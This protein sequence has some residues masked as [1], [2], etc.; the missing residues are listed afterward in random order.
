MKLKPG[1]KV[2]DVGCGFGFL[3]QTYW[4]FFGKSG[5]YTGI[6]I[7]K[8]NL[9]KAKKNSLKWAKKGK[10]SFVCGDVYSL[11]CDEDIFDVTMCQTL[12]MHLTDPEKALKEM[13]RITKPGGLV[14][15]FE[16]DNINF[17]SFFSTSLI[18]TIEERLLIKKADLLRNEGRLKLG[19]GDYSFGVKVPY[20]MFNVG[21][22][23]IDA[24]NGDSSWITLPPYKRQQIDWAKGKKTKRDGSLYQKE[25]MEELRA[26]GASKSFV[27]KYKKT[28]LKIKR[29]F[30]KNARTQ[31]LKK[32]YFNY[33]PLPNIIASSGRKPLKKKR[34]R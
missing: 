27:E 13:I 21:L 5:S 29:E 18:Y 26:S 33:H 8:Q 23:E 25:Y 9:I 11:P 3:G 32:D 24:R 17:N 16:P 2:A 20:L 12:L 28:I 10:V 31:I 22:K 15:C 1:I 19:R 14:C 6:D 4:K 7:N 34:S 30:R